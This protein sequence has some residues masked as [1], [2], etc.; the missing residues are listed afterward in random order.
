[1]KRKFLFIIALGSI[2]IF[3]GC[4]SDEVKTTT[5]LTPS[6]QN[7]KRFQSVPPEKT[8]MLQT[9]EKKYTCPEC[10]M[11]LPM[12]YKTNHSAISNGK[13]KQY[14]SLHCLVEDKLNKKS[15]LKDIE[16]IAIDTLKFIDATQ[17]T[18]VVGSQKS[19]TMSTLSKYAFEGRMSAKRFAKENGGKVM[20]FNEAYGYA[21]RDFK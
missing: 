16:V 3:N 1:M 12:F 11:K 2:L 17:A 19:G 5:N 9:G 18:Y 21:L 4:V 13:V 6:Q 14:C 8:V 10:G 7:F 20:K 15:E